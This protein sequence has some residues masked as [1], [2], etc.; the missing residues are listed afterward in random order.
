[1][2]C[3]FADLCG[4]GSL[5]RKRPDRHSAVFSSLRGK[6]GPEHIR[7]YYLEVRLLES[8][9]FLLRSSFRAVTVLIIKERVFKCG[10][11]GFPLCV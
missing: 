1:M 4:T 7:K 11:I 6:A 5:W 10:Y 2:V 8:M 3:V 9:A